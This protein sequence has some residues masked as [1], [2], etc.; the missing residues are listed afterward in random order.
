MN[1]MLGIN[2]LSVSLCKT[3]PKRYLHYAKNIYTYACT[4]MRCV[5]VFIFIFICMYVQDTFFFNPESQIYDHFILLVSPYP[6]GRQMLQSSNN[7]YIYI[8]GCCIWGGTQMSI[9][10]NHQSQ[11][12]CWLCTSRCIFMCVSFQAQL[13]ASQR[14]LPQGLYS[15]IEY[16][17]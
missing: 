1:T 9:S 13:E 4:Y 7:S 3:C 15:Y 11:T 8:T 10:S 6:F 17:A 12:P 2:S 14:W 16:L 5:Y